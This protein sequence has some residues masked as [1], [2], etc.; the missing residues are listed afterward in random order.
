MNKL[1]ITKKLVEFDEVWNGDPKKVA[2]LY[3][4][5]WASW[6]RD[7]N[8][9][10]RLTDQGFDYFKNTAQIKFYDIR[11]PADLVLT[12]KM[13]IDLDKFIDCPYYLTSNSIMLT[14][15]KAALQLILFDGDLSK[16]GRAKR[17]TKLRNPKK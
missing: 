11:F 1:E 7:Q 5:C 6:R 2:M 15:E 16:F 12:N 13:V 14:S 9:H 17:E 8:K 4:S 10:F 3:K